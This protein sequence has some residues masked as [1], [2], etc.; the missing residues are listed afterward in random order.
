MAIKEEIRKKIV[1]QILVGSLGAPEE[2]VT[3]TTIITNQ[4]Q[5]SSKK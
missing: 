4:Q 5:A 3:L 2:M 1:T